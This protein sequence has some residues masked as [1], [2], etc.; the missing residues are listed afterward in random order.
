[1]TKSSRQEAAANLRD[2]ESPTPCLKHTYFF[3]GIS[4]SS[5][6]LWVPR[7]TQFAHMLCNVW[8]GRQLGGY[9]I[10]QKQP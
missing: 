7:L 10:Q 5:Y 6:S 9:T 3:A 1:M 2:A 8:G 4:P